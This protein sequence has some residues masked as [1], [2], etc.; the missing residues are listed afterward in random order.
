MISLLLHRLFSFPVLLRQGGGG[1]MRASTL[2]TSMSERYIQTYDGSI[3]KT[4]RSIC[5]H[6]CLAHILTGHIN[7][8]TCT[9]PLSEKHFLCTNECRWANLRSKVHRNIYFLQFR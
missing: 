3:F 4:Q 1:W 8:H 6:F 9:S 7:Q 2:Q 5:R